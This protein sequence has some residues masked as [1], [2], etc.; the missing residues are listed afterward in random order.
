MCQPNLSLRIV[1]FSDR[2]LGVNRNLPQLQ[3][4]PRMSRRPTILRLDSKRTPLARLESFI[5]EPR[6]D[7]ALQITGRIC[8]ELERT[9]EPGPWIAAARTLAARGDIS[10]NAVY[11]L[12]EMF[13]DGITAH[14][15][16]NDPEMLRLYGEM[17][18]VKREHGMAE[19]DDWRVDEGPAEWQALN[20][21]WDRRDD[22]IRVATLRRMGHDDIAD[23]L[24]HD[25]EEFGRREESGRYD[26]W[27]A[28]EEEEE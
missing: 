6:R 26:L 3:Q 22:E 28:R 7:R 20:S 15:A 11:H 13:L 21:A 8:E 2:A 24:E 10:T 16:S 17:D 5:R 12:V 19:D 27:G 9:P 18:R 25:P 4:L 14:A 23:V 1:R